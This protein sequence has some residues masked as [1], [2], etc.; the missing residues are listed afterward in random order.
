MVHLE[1]FSFENETRD[2]IV[3]QAFWNYMIFKN[4][5]KT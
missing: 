5:I 1:G 2:F 4:L 3:V